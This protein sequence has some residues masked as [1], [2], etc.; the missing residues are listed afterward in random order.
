MIINHEAMMA[1]TA[2]MPMKEIVI[3][4]EAYLQ[5]HFAETRING[6]QVWYHRFLRNDAER[7]LHN[8]P[9]KAS[10]IILCGSYTEELMD[11]SREGAITHERRLAGTTHWIGYDTTHRIIQVEPNTWTMMI[12]E[13]C[14]LPT[15]QFIADDGTITVMETSP[16]EWHKDF[17][18]RATL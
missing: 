3:N 8:H 1:L 12:V 2:D 13:R 6:T 16:F 17:K 7:H 15:W 9:W 11:Y 14:R 18:P 4:G 10:S 5:R